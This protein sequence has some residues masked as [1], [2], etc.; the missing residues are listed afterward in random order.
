MLEKF[1]T[2]F[3]FRLKNGCIPWDEDEDLGLNEDSARGIDGASGLNNLSLR[4]KATAMDNGSGH[5]R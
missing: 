1:L 2:S 4:N 5:S 3:H